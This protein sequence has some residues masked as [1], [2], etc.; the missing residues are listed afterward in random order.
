[1]KRIHATAIVT[2]YVVQ[3]FA[4][5]NV[6]H[7][8]CVRNAVSHDIIEAKPEEGTAIRTVGT[9]PLPT[10]LALFDFAPKSFNVVG[11]QESFH[12]SRSHKVRISSDRVEPC[13]G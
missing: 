8:K 5:G 7:T 13:D 1:M 12:F 6:S 2:F 3:L 10:S 4:F 9:K 11:T